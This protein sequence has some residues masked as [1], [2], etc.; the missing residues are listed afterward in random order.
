MF[1]INVQF[2]VCFCFCF[3]SVLC[4]THSLL[5]NPD[6]ATSGVNADIPSSWSVIFL[7]FFYC[8]ILRW[9]ST[10]KRYRSYAG[11]CPARTWPTARIRAW[12]NRA[13][14]VYSAYRFLTGTSACATNGATRPTVTRCRSTARRSYTTPVAKCKTGRPLDLLKRA[15][16]NYYGIIMGFIFGNI[17]P[18]KKTIINTD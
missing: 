14:T 4:L 8:L 13:A 3:F 16:D 10:R 6:Y 15:I 12:P 2:W 9:W 17:V 5:R 1:I 18:S 7:L 11:R